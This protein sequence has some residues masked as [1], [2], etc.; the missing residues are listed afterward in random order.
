MSTIGLSPAETRWFSSWAVV[1]IQGG[2]KMALARREDSALTKEQRKYL[3]PVIL[4]PQTMICPLEVADLIHR[5]RTG[6]SNLIPDDLAEVCRNAAVLINA[7]EQNVDFKMFSDEEE[8]TTDS[9]VAQWISLAQNAALR[10]H[11]YIDTYIHTYIHISSRM[12][13]NSQRVPV[14]MLMK[15]AKLSQ[16]CTHRPT[17]R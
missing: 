12:D 5:I 13:Q 11:T 1:I 14:V 8:L 16:R 7:W 4:V 15:E 3:D 6:Q 2:R 17:L 10:T 9:I